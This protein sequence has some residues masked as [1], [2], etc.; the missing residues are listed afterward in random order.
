VT[1]IRYPLPDGTSLVS[2]VDPVAASIETWYRE[3]WIRGCRRSM[4]MLDDVG[5][6]SSVSRVS[7]WTG[8]N[9]RGGYEGWL[10][11]AIT[12]RAR[13]EELMTEASE[14]RG[15]NSYNTFDGSVIPNY[16][17]FQWTTA[18]ISGV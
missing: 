4:E 11:E 17:Y 10:H 3:G 6:V 8:G 5:V 7:I 13:V 1:E 12:D 2:S 14:F 9:P 18:T 15:R 16:N